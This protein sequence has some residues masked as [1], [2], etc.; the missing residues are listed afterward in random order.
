M[1]KELMGFLPV[2]GNLIQGVTGKNQR[3]YAATLYDANAGIARL[4]AE[5]AITRGRQDEN[6]SRIATKGLIGRQR[7]AMGAQGIDIGRD[8]AMDVQED[9][10]AMGELE[11]LTIRNNAAREAWGYRVQAANLGSNASLQRKAGRTQLYGSI[12]TAGI[13]A[14]D[15][16]KESGKPTFE[17]SRYR[18]VWGDNPEY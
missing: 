10:A 14:Y 8:S 18:R 15:L 1:F 12:T 9:A 17:S 3:D 7:A 13:R 5:D 6:M 11:A 16:L 2:I 4:Q